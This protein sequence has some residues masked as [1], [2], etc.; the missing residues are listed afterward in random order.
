MVQFPLGNR[1]DA[2]FNNTDYENIPNK[3]NMQ[4]QDEQKLRLGTQL[5]VVVQKNKNT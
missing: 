1:R 4:G 2:T 3:I 5:P